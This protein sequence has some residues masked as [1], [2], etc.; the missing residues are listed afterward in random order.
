MIALPVFFL[1]GTFLLTVIAAGFRQLRKFMT[2][3]ELASIGSFW[4]LRRLQDRL[5]PGASFEVLLFTTVVTQNI[6]RLAFAMGA[7]IAGLRLEWVSIGPDSNLWTWNGLVLSVGLMLFISAS[8]L[9][10]DF[11]PRSWGNRYPQTAIKACAPL[12]T[13]Y[14]L[15]C[16]P[17][18]IL[19]VKLFRSIDSGKDLN[20]DQQ[21]LTQVKDKVIEIIEAANEDEQLDPNEKKIIESA[22]TFRDRIAREVMVPRVDV[23][24]LPAEMS[25]REAADILSIEGYSR[26]PVYKGNVDNIVGVLMYRD[27]MSLYLQCHKGSR[28]PKHLDDPIESITKAI[29]YSPETKK[30]SDLLQEFRRK[31]THLAVVV[32]EYG[33]TE[34]IL[35]IEDILEEIVGEIADEY[36][37]EELLF[38]EDSDGSWVIDARMSIL[39]IE[40][41][42]GLKVPQDGEYDTIGGY[43]FHRAG[44]VPNKGLVIHHDDFELEILSS[45]DRCVEKIRARKVEAPHS[46]EV[47]RSQFKN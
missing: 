14:L 15:L 23:F 36:D 6:C 10:I 39:D 16:L 18:T 28:D 7:L 2:K 43:V 12:G 1:I 24:S 13:G 5:F 45:T 44:A 32:D 27:V 37:E 20:R 3:E 40:D 42:L 34:G 21:A 4:L 30:I 35:T 26:T 41:H 11:I 17:L 47:H 38:L 8:V 33:G 31:Q 22:M 46:K 25:V 9:V 29:L 19:F